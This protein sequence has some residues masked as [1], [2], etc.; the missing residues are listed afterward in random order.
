MVRTTLLF[1]VSLLVIAS[2]T[3]KISKANKLAQQTEDVSYLSAID[4]V[5]MQRVKEL[6]KPQGWLSVIGLHWLQQGV[7]T[8]GATPDNTIV[9]PRIYTETIGA[10]QLTGDEVFFGKVEGVEVNS[11]GQEYLGGPVIVD[12][13]PTVINHQSLYWYILKR[14]ERFAIRL[15]DTLSDNRLQFS[16]LEYFETNSSYQVEAT[17]RSPDTEATVDITNVLGKTIAY[18]IAAHLD[19]ELGG[20]KHSL[21]ALDE[22]T[23]TFF[24][25]FGDATNSVASYGGGRFL[26]PSKV[27]Y[28]AITTLDFNLA[29]N[30]PC[31]FTDFATCPL[32]PSGNKLQIPILAGEKTYG[33][34]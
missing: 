8:I 34:H 5:R 18:P 19:F 28:G 32:P 23:D 7:N 33:N 14:E 25:I 10:Y 16:G 22:G 3:N 1:L 20:N 17:V 21:L 15:K 12:Y 9:F 6:T 31:A 11:N 26:Y 4:S 27:E 29:E 30:P 24:V 2:C 13:P